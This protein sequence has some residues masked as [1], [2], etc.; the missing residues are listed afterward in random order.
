MVDELANTTASSFL[1]NSPLKKKPKP[2]ES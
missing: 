2:R 1:E